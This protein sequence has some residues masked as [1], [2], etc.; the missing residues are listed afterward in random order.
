MSS[1]RK[2]KL[3]DSDSLRTER[4]DLND[5]IKEARKRLKPQKSFNA[6]YIHIAIIVQYMLINPSYWT[7]RV[8]ITHKLSRSS[9]LNLRIATL[10][11]EQ[12]ERGDST[13]EFLDTAEGRK[14]F[15]QM[16]AAELDERICQQQPKRITTKTFAQSTRRAFIELY[17]SAKHGL[18]VGCG[19]GR[20]ST[21]IQS[22]FREALLKASNSKHPDAQT[23]LLWCPI[24]STWRD[25]ANTK[26]AHIFGKEWTSYV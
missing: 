4:G 5:N 12:Y 2:A 22:N 23:G 19:A 14:Y 16:K 25:P 20:R 11:Y 15:E 24:T 8:E 18:G 1:K 10:E 3:E 26:A 17:T 6:E 7:D 21:R 13:T 9:Q